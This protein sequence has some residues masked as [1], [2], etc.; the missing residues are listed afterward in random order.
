VAAKAEKQEGP[1]M[2]LALM[3]SIVAVLLVAGGVRAADESA[4]AKRYL[5]KAFPPAEKG[6][7]RFAIILPKMDDESL[8]KVE[9]IVGKKMMADSVNRFGLGGA[10]EEVNIDGWGF[11][12]YVVKE[13]GP[14]AQTLIGGG[15]P[16]EKFVTVQPLLIRYNSRLPIAVYVPE[17]AEVKYRVW[18]TTAD[19]KD[20]PRG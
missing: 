9:L 10:I 13:F 12:R 14:A 16:Q 15:V 3:F 17:G 1:T 6:M 7:T 2:K 19:T 20:I 8:Y 11:T 18:S 5:E 4:E